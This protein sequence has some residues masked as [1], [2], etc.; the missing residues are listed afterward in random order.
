LVCCVELF[1]IDSVVVI[2]QEVKLLRDLVPNG[3]PSGTWKYIA[4]HFASRGRTAQNCR[5]KYL[6][7]AEQRK[8]GQNWTQ[9]EDNIL[10]S[11]QDQMGN[12]WKLI[13]KSIV[14]RSENDV[15]VR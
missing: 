13:S 9:E 7:I 10:I 15:K 5:E 3:E 8:K 14:G 11:L 12:R 6:A 4:S 1:G 2:I